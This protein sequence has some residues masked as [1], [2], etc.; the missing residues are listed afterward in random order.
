MLWNYYD[1]DLPA[2]DEMVSIIVSSVPAKKV[3]VTQYMIDKNHSNS[4]E[5]WKKMGSPQN[6]TPTQYAELEKAGQLQITGSP[7]TKSIKSGVL[8]IPAVLPRQAVAFFK[9]EWK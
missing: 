1:D 4:Y 9:I 5:I 2:A 8:I 6:P 3:Q 7:V